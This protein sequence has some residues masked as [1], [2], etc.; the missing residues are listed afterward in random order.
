M[1]NYFTII[2]DYCFFL[3][4]LSSMLYALVMC[5]YFFFFFIQECDHAMIR[6]LG[7]MCTIYFIL[8]TFVYVGLSCYFT[9]LHRSRTN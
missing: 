6:T 7:C 4:T 5:T 3:A 8:F 9:T 1:L 2:I